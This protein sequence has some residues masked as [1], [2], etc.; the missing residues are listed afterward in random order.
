[1]KKISAVN[2][3]LQPDKY[4]FLK[5]EVIYLGYII[6]ENGVKPDPKKLIAVKNFPLPK[7]RKNVK[8]FLESRILPTIY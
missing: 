1:M 4:E 5:R 7:T 8:L 6:I 2:L 3:S